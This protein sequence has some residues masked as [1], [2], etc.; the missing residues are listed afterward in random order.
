M[1]Y[2]GLSRGDW[3]AADREIKR[4]RDN[5][6]HYPRCGITIASGVSEDWWKQLVVVIQPHL[7]K[8]FVK[9][10]RSHEWE[11]LGNAAYAAMLYRVAME[12]GLITGAEVI[13]AHAANKFV[14]EACIA[15]FPPRLMEVWPLHR[16]ERF[17]AMNVPEMIGGAW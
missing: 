1:S 7:V 15:G 6:T 5:L 10:H 4:M 14:C 16:W 17:C 8:P 2:H 13:D 11:T 12:F 3:T 9:P